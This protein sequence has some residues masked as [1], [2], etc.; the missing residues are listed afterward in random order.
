MTGLDFPQA[1]VNFCPNPSAVSIRYIQ[2][3]EPGPIWKYRFFFP[4][5]KKLESFGGIKI[6]LLLCICT[7]LWYLNSAG[8]A[9]VGLVASAWGWWSTL[10][11][12]PGAWFCNASPRY[13]FP[14]GKPARKGRNFLFIHKGKTKKLLQNE[15]N[16][17]VWLGF[18]QNYRISFK[19]Y[20]NIFVKHE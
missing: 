7:T 9:P 1:L 3:F 4:N 5:K 13:P 15:I 19:F 2:R 18:V 14:P 12:R 17:T 6:F 11:C 16:V 8:L 20:N 10:C